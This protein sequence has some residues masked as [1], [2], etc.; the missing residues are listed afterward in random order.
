MFFLFSETLSI[1]VCLLSR[2]SGF[3]SRPCSAQSRASQS[4]S[5]TSLFISA[6]LFRRSTLPA[7]VLPRQPSEAM[8]QHF[9]GTTHRRVSPGVQG[10]FAFNKNS[11]VRSKRH[12]IARAWRSCRGYGKAYYRIWQIRRH[13]RG[14]WAWQPSLTSSWC[15]AAICTRPA[16]RLPVNLPPVFQATGSSGAVLLRRRLLSGHS[17]KSPHRYYRS[18]T[19]QYASGKG[20]NEAIEELLRLVRRVCSC[21]MKRITLSEDGSWAGSITKFSF[22]RS[23]WRSPV[24]RRA[25]DNKSLSAFPAELVTGAD[26]RKQTQYL[27]PA[28]ETLLRDAHAGGLHSEARCGSRWLTIP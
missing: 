19:Y 22:T 2:R 10:R 20:R 16:R 8:Q 4:S 3:V 13:M 7:I 21:S 26:G 17:R 1:F 14:T 18:P 9:H 12:R 27:H 15:H 25:S 24:R 6:G 11:R 28:H 5:I 23:A